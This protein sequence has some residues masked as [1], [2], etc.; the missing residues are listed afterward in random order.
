M[1]KLYLSHL[2]EKE[3]NRTAGRTCFWLTQQ[4]LEVQILLASSHHLMTGNQRAHM[5][6]KTLFVY[7]QLGP[8]SSSQD[9]PA[10][11]FQSG[12]D[13][14]AQTWMPFTTQEYIGEHTCK[15]ENSSK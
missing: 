2:R 12:E 14:H 3:R 13:A 4:T 6:K 11:N 10:L 9:V 1:V 15:M 7:T 8:E 5:D